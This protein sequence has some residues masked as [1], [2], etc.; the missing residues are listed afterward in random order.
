MNGLS[1]WNNAPC[2]ELLTFPYR[3][4]ELKGGEKPPHLLLPPPGAWYRKWQ[5]GPS[6]QACTCMCVCVC[7]SIVSVCHTR[8]FSAD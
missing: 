8:V 7:A 6:S 4:E 1:G 3:T 2:S 5:E